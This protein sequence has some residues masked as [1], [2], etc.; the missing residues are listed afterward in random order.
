MF[1]IQFLSLYGAI[2]CLIERLICLFYYKRNYQIVNV[3][4]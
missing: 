1:E 4:C 2:E 3:I